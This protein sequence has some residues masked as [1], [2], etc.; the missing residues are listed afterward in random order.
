MALSITDLDFDNIQK[1]FKDF[2][3]TQDVF[4]DYNF[5]GSAI[6]E[7]LR[8]LSYNTFY[9][10]FYINNIANEMFLDSATERS[11]VVSRAK[12]LGYTPTSQISSKA[13]VDLTS[14]ISKVSGEST[15]TSNSFI[16]LNSYSYFTSSVQEKDYNFL[17]TEPHNLYYYGDGGDHHIYKKFNVPL[18]EG[19]FL[20]YSF[21]VEREYD[22]YIIPNIGID[23]NTLIVRIYSSP[24][25]ISYTTYI[26]ASNLIDIDSSSE[27]YWIYEGDDQKYYLE[28]GNDIYGKKLNIGNIIYIEYIVCNG[29]LANGCKN[30]NVGSY[31]YS[32]QYL[33]ETKA[34][35]VDNSID[36]V[37]N[38]YNQ[39]SDFSSNCFVRSANSTASGYVSNYLNGVL[40]LTEVSNTFLIGDTIY[41]YDTMTSSNG[42]V[43]LVSSSKS[44]ENFSS[45]GS[46]IESLN[47]IKFHAP[48]FY[49]SQNR[50]V[51][52]SDYESIIKH[53]Y[54]YI[55]S[56]VCWGGE[57]LVPEQLG[58]VFVSVKPRGREILTNTEKEFLLN[59][60]IEPRK[61]MN[62]N[63]NII[64]ADFIYLQ[65]T[66]AI[67]YKAD[68]SSD[69]TQETI[70][71]RVTEEVKNYCRVN[72]GFFNN[73]FYYSNFVAMIDDSNEFII[74]NITDV[75]MI[76]YFAPVLLNT[77]TSSNNAVLYFNNTFTS[78]STSKFSCNTGATIHSN[79]SFVINS[80]NSTILSIANSSGGYAVQNAGTLD[81]VNGIISI[82]NTTI[83]STSEQNS[84]NTNVI[85]FYVVP[86]EMDLISGRNQILKIY[87]SFTVTSIPIR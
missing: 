72:C 36:V 67:K 39:T 23:I 15:P 71:S 63:V 61:I 3:K 73:K 30:F 80:S 52:K 34:L 64:D 20:S 51:T 19:K 55:D 25:S 81:Y 45:G 14:Y 10:S 33:Q 42:S 22:K 74:S 76:K 62:V 27:I 46:D 31:A 9:N 49:A 6:S 2:L 78:L 56:V 35:R 69:I 84:S 58:E 7:L 18:K 47:S 75:T 17:T 4:K 21:K 65:P 13:Y 38:V 37:L 59:T 1:N 60:V 26:K 32:D 85:K 87:D 5:D 50:L 41:E 53:E 40:K 86:E 44:E 70:E 77:Y 24:D 57:E 79:C 16:T 8:L 66:I 12:G 28:F 43:A 48:K 11:S 83:T 82:A 68:L 29:S 54:P